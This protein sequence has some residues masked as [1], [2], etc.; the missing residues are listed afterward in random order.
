MRGG[1]VEGSYAQK[2]DAATMPQ[3]PIHHILPEVKEA[4]AAGSAVLAAP[5]GSGKTTVVPLALRN[6]PWLAGRKI[7]MLEPR[8]LAAR[9]AAGRMAGLVGERIGETVGYQIRF[10]RQISAVTRIEVLTEGILTRRLQNEPDLPGVGL[11]IFDEFHERSIHADLALALCL[12][13]CQLRGDLRLLVMSATLDT[14]AVA[15]LLGGVPVVTGEGRSYPVK[16]EYLQRP[17]TGS[18]AEATAAGVRRVAA[19]RQGDVLVFLPGAG[20]IREVRRRLAEDSA[21]ADM[22]IAP[23]FGELPQ[24]EQ[25]RAL[26]PDPGGR[27]RVILATSIAE[28]SLTIEGVGCV[29]DG[30]WSRRPLFDPGNGLGRLTTVRVS[31]ASADQRAGRAGRLGPGYCLRLWTKEEHHNLAPFHPPEIVGA[32]LAQVV[33]ELALWGV[34]DPGELRWLDPPR[35]GAC[36]QARELLRSL[37]A[38]DGRGRITATGRRLVALPAHPR[39]GHMLLAANESGHGPLACDLAAILAERDPLR[40]GD[41]APSAELRL[42]VALLDRWRRGGDEAVRRQGGDPSLCR[43][44]DR[45]ARRWRELLQCRDGRHDPV[46]I[47]DLLVYAYPDR[48]ARRRPAARDRYQLAGGR[49][50]VLPPADPLAAAE[51][52]VVAALDAGRTEGRIFLAESVEPATL[53]THHRDLF[54]TVDEIFWDD[55]AARVMAVRRLCLGKLIVEENPLAEAAPEALAQA[56]LTGIRRLGLVCLP[57]DRESRQLQARVDCLRRQQPEIGWPELTD[58]RLLADLDW[59]APYLAGLTRADQLKQLDLGRILTARLSWE[60]QRRLEHDAPAAITVASGSKIRIDYRLGEPPVLAVRLQ[61]MFGE[62]ATPTVCGGRLPLLL[63]LLSPARRPIAVT[64]DLA[65]FWRHSY[66]EVKKELKGRY[67]KHYWPDDPLA[68]EAIRGVKKR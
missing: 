27:R 12:D 44:L 16:V 18:I 64:A 4:L 40:R 68:A 50:A 42:R 11:V 6:E 60:Q 34:H 67:P 23:L 28:T 30:G 9:A 61:E 62:T 59:L 21:F 25:D 63:H 57:W 19:E 51:Y 39:L 65:S 8:R 36:R 5:P 15:D 7:L 22:L 41:F 26:L 20:E 32:D 17:A 2:G 37:G 3:L 46:A 54:Q 47:G 1:N 35:E 58:D 53:L 45:E 38:L 31:K 66:P 14:R 29:V 55:D 43:R 13:L 33:L 56:M 10:D 52:L 48:I 49:G 24:T